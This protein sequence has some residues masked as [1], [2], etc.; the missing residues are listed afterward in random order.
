MEC[1]LSDNMEITLIFLMITKTKMENKISKFL[2]NLLSC[3]LFLIFET[4]L[5]TYSK[6]SD[7]LW[8][9]IC[10][11]SFRLRCGESRTDDQSAPLFCNNEITNHFSCTHWMSEMWNKGVNEWYGD[12]CTAS[13]NGIS[14]PNTNVNCKFDTQTDT[15]HEKSENR[16]STLCLRH[17][18]HWIQH[19]LPSV[20]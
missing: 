16:Q 12:E 14:Q 13:M 9:V 19:T 20:V 18:R 17:I 11:T 8:L 6:R 5:W 4:I 15:Y 3:L 7:R 1:I 10:C 2:I